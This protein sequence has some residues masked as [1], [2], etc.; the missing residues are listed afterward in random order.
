M[1]VITNDVACSL[2]RILHLDDVHV[3]PDGAGRYRIGA[4]EVDEGLPA[5]VTVPIDPSLAADVLNRAA[6]AVAPL[7][8]ATVEAI[9]LGWRPLPADGFSA[10]GSLAGLDGYYLVFTHSG[11]TLGPYLGTL[12]A[13]EIANGIVRSELAQFRPDRLVRSL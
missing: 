12:V 5:N 6:R 8:S 13:D 7:R 2:D 11:V 1:L 10:V 3:R 4:V 9:R